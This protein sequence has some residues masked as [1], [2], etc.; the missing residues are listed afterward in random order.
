MNLSKNLIKFFD[1]TQNIYINISI[2]IGLILIFVVLP[3]P[4]PNSLNIIAKLIIIC[5]L[6][7]IVLVNI[8]NNIKLVN[9]I[10]KKKNNDSIKISLLLS[11]ILNILL[12]SLIIYLWYIIFF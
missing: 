5:S 9:S 1:E 6:I 4:I 7:Y 2:I 3:L 12:I 10:N 11:C 8:N